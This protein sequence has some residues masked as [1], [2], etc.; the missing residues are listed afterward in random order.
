MLLRKSS[1][2]LVRCLLA[3]AAL[4][5]AG[6]SGAADELDLAIKM[7]CISCHRGAEKLIGPPYADVAAKYAG[8]KDAAPMLADHIVKGTGPSGVGWMKEGKALLPFMPANTGVTPEEA[9]RLA[10]WV[11]GMK[12]E[13]P[14]LL[15]YVSQRLSVAGTV[16]QALDL[17]V[18]DLRA[19]PAPELKE[20]TVASQSPAKAGTPMSFKGVSLRTLLE[21]AVVLA[22]GRHDL[23]KIV[24]FA[25]A[26]DD[27][28]VV[29]SWNEIF[30]SPVGEGVLV[31]FEKDG[32]P[33]G[34][35]EGRIALI[36]TRDLHLG[37][38]HVRWLNAIEVRK[39]ID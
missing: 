35:D 13:I 39:V 22:P 37:A 26:S 38:R 18:D 8:Q 23:K 5:M 24:I 21:K 31:Y 36:S 6:L 25:K 28:A 16:K 17:S 12:G 2:R 32:K 19:F 11:L 27:Y 3:T 14:G 20:I 1:H 9:A 33:L 34:A 30:N 4:P 29:F 15:K 7:G 10:D